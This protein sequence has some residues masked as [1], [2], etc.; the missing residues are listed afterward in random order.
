[1]QVLKDP[2]L[3]R[4]DVGFGERELDES[5]EPDHGVAERRVSVGRFV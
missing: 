2:V 5:T 4:G 3:G 1:M